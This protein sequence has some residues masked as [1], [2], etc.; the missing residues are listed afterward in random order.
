MEARSISLNLRVRSLDVMPLPMRDWDR[1]SSVCSTVVPFHFSGDGDVF[2]GPH[3]R[4]VV[5]CEPWCHQNEV[6]NLEPGRRLTVSATPPDGL[7]G[8]ADIRPY[9]RPGARN[10]QAT[11]GV[12]IKLLTTRRCVR[13]R[14]PRRVGRIGGK[15]AEQG[16]AALTEHAGAHV[17]QRAAEA[18]IEMLSKVERG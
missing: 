4:T 7:D 15:L 2:P 9:S 1:T 13:R 16:V 5:P 11:V 14:W 12:T 10:L 18:C 17:A 6:S 3:S 8:A